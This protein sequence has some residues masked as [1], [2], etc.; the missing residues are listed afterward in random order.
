MIVG[1]QCPGCNKIRAPYTHDVVQDGIE[2]KI[3]VCIVCKTQ[4]IDRFSDLPSAQLWDGRAFTNTPYPP[5][6]NPPPP[7][8]SGDGG[9]DTGK[10]IY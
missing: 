4:D 5:Y 1:R 9:G 8:P 7:P 6:Y 2:Y 3:Y 10:P